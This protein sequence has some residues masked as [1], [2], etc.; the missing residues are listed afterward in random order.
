MKTENAWKKYAD[1]TEV[2]DFCEKYK[3]FMSTCKTERE[4]VTEMV[5]KAE[6]AGYR[7]LKNHRKGR[8]PRSRET[9]YMP[10]IRENVWQCISSEKNLWK[11]V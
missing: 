7:N 4:C 2:F 1:K 8:K 5:Q 9:R 11:K 3:S 10:I 6:T